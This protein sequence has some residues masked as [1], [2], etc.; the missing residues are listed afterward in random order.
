M[1]K[2]DGARLLADLRALAQIG[3]Y[4][5]GVHRPT[6]SPQDMQS[7]EWLMQRM[8][9]AGLEPEMDGIGN[10]IGRSSGNGPKLLLGSHI[11]TQNHAGWLDG[12]MGVIYGLEVARASPAPPPARAWA[13]TSPPGLT[14]KAITA[15]SL[16]ASR[17]AAS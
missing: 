6:Y 13:S 10:V 11:E 4:K 3:A 9:D 1:P 2:I 14:R 7:R 8:R 12:A 5:T 17:S 15:A 16:A